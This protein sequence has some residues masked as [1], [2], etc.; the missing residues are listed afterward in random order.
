MFSIYS[1]AVNSIPRAECLATFGEERQ[2][3]F[4]RYRVATLRTLIT[5][6]FLTTNDF[7]V[8]QALFLFLLGDPESELSSSLGG[9]AARLAQKM[10]LCRENRKASFFDKEMGLRLWWQ[11]GGLDARALVV[12]SPGGPI[13]FPKELGKVRLPMNVNDA[14]LHPDMAE[15]PAEQDGPTE[16]ACVLMK[17]AVPHWL[18]SARTDAAKTFSSIVRGP[19]RG[20]MS[21]TLDDAVVDEL[22]NMCQSR[23][24]NIDRSIP[25]HNITYVYMKLA[26][27]RM[28]FKVHHPRGRAAVKGGD[29]YMTREKSDVLFEA[30]LTMLEMVDQGM[31]SK[32]SSHMFTRLATEL[33]V[34]VVVYVVSDLR[35]RVSGERVTLAWSLME[36]VYARHPDLIDDSESSLF[37]AL[38]DLVLEA[39]EARSKELARGGG[40]QES[41][42]TPKFVQRLWDRR[43]KMN[44][45]SSQAPPVPETQGMGIEGLGLTDDDRFDWEYWNDFLQL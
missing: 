30:A 45:E 4:M 34:D 38:G 18:G 42:A 26:S 11:I 28:R 6:N 27:S 25:L 40:G 5:A 32:F 8:L 20:H 9:A 14:D 17:L 16:M 31:R 15:A 29:V 23:L 7:E 36:G 35:R 22:E 3:L 2:T 24:R 43:Q 12:H 19:V 41:D 1:L 13:Q 33:L 21:T 37:V 10:G 44:E 39:W